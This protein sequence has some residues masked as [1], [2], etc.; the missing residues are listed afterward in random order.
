[1]GV[2][3]FMMYNGD[4]VTIQGEMLKQ[5]RKAVSTLAINDCADLPD[6]VQQSIRILTGA[7]GYRIGANISLVNQLKTAPVPAK[8]GGRTWE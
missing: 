2:K 3:Q 8:G 7:F 5:I 1:M 6:E 4:F